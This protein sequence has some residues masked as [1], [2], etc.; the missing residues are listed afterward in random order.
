MINPTYHMLAPAPLSTTHLGGDGPYSYFT[1][2]EQQA[3][4]KDIMR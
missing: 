4:P 2:A 3:S 1:V